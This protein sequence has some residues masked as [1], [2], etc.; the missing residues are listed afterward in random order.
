MVYVKNNTTIPVPQVFGFSATPHPGVGCRYILMESLPG[1]PGTGRFTEF[2]PN[3]HKKKTFAQLAD[4]KVQLSKLRFPRI[5]RLLGGGLTM[6]ESYTIEAFRPVGCL[7]SEPCGPFDSAIDY[8]FSIRR[9]DLDMAMRDDNSH[10]TQ[11]QR[12]GAWLR[13]QAVPI[14]VQTEFNHGP[15]PLHHPDLNIANLMFDDE[16]NITGVIDWTGAFVAP[17]ECFCIMPI[18]F[19]RYSKNPLHTEINLI[20]ELMEEAERQ[21][22]SKVPLSKYMKSPR[23]AGIPAFEIGDRRG[24]KI[25]TQLCQS[26]IRHMYGD[27]AVYNQIKSMFDGSRWMVGLVETGDEICESL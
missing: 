7:Y 14:I 21:I 11:D 9:R 12:F 19:Q 8:Y 6:Q 1:T 26:L 20:W 5:G 18:E 16:F 17:V 22:D 4:I 3:D 15:F 24:E 13:V 10:I 25:T 27:Q 2:V 23:S